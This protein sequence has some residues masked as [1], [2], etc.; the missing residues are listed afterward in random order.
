[1]ED[2]VRGGQAPMSGICACSTTAIHAECLEKLINLKKAR[3]RGLDERMNCMVC[4]SHYT[5]AF[6]P[7]VIAPPRPGP[8]S[9]IVRVVTR[10]SLAPAC[11]GLL[12]LVLIFVLN[13]LLGRSNTFYVFV[14]CVFFFA[15]CTAITLRRRRH[16]RDVQSLD[17]NRFHSQ[18]VSRARKE[19]GRGFEASYDEALHAPSQSVVLLIQTP[20]NPTR[21]RSRTDGAR[22]LASDEQPSAELQQPQPRSRIVP[23]HD[24]LAPPV[25]TPFGADGSAAN[26]SHAP[27]GAPSALSNPPSAAPADSDLESGVA[28]VGAPAT[29]GSQAAAAQPMTR[30]DRVLSSE[31]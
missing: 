27:A 8:L 13:Y 7:Y 31:F 25:A 30:F 10:S 11:F 16:L 3:G 12:V 2:D 1:M 24:A 28:P 17:D 9:R 29:A 22:V 6:T 18:V 14:A 21:S 23:E 5:C 4:A 20:R 26:E 19:V 15:A